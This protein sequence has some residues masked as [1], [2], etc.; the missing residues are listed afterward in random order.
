MVYSQVGRAIEDLQRLATVSQSKETA[1]QQ[2]YRKL[3]QDLLVHV[4]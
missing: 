4:D 1:G 3:R 2:T